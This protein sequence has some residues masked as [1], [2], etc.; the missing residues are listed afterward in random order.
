MIDELKEAL[1]QWHQREDMQDWCIVTKC[2]LDDGERAKYRAEI[3]KPDGRVFRS[4]E[5]IVHAANGKDDYCTKAEEGAILKALS[6]C[7][8]MILGKT[9]QTEEVN[10]TVQKQMEQ[11]EEEQEEISKPEKKTKKKTKSISEAQIDGLRATLKEV[12]EQIFGKQKYTLSQISKDV[13]KKPLPE[14]EEDA[15]TILNFLLK[16]R[17]KLEE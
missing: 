11:K 10:D 16:M 4:A 12:N 9:A 7:P 2:L 17:E 3:I 1:E 6:Y 13:L 15:R 14:T 8:G 5:K